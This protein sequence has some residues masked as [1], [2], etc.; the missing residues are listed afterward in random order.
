MHSDPNT[1]ETDEF[2]ASLGYIVNSPDCKF[3]FLLKKKK[4]KKII[5]A[6]WSLFEL[7]SH[8]EVHFN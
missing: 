6:H 4:K 1:W 2:K 5:K 8:V 7:S 3:F